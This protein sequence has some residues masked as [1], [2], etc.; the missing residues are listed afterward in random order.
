MPGTT[1]DQTTLDLLDGALEV[2]A[3]T[4]RRD[5]SISS[6]PIWVVVADGEAY[7][8]SYRGPGGAWYRRAKDDGRLTLVAG[9]TEIEAAVEPATEDDINRRVSDAYRSKYG[10]R[11]PGPTE[12]MVDPEVSATTL[13]LAAP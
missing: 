7:V 6:R 3:R 12:T 11:S 9:Q 13:R 2:D 10:A 4:P 1:L 5:G 8:R